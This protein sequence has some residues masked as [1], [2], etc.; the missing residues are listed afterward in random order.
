[1]S[2]GIKRLGLAVVAVVAIGFSALSAV[3]LLVSADTVRERVKEQIRT[4]TGLDPVLSGDVTVSLFPTGSVQFSNISLGDHRTGT[5]ALTA[6][7]LVVRLQFFPFLTGQIEIAD[8]TLVRPTITIAF[9]QGSS[10]WSDHVDML[11]NALRPNPNRVKSF[12]E[13]RISDGT[14]IVRN[15]NDK[16]V[17][18]LTDVEFALAW[19]AISQ[20]FAATGRF[21]WHDEPIDVTLSLTDFLAA[22]TGERSGLKLRL[23]GPPLKFAYDG[24]ISHRPTLK[25]EGALSAD[26]A[27]LRDTLR[28]AARWT[29]PAGGFNRFT[30]KAQ[31]NVS[32]RSVSLSGVNVELDGNVGEGVLSFGGDRRKLL[33]GTLAAGAIDLTP[34]LSTLHLLADDE[35]NRQPITLAGLAGI[36]V[37]LRLSAG[38]VSL[39]KINLGRTAVATNL[40]GGDLTVAVGESQAFGGIAGGTFGLAQSEAG[41]AFKAQMKFT[42][43]DLTQGLGEL[44]GIRRIEGKGTVVVNV[45]GAGVSV[46][47]L[48]QGLNGTASLIST[49]GAIQGVNVEQLLKRLEHNPLAIRGDFRNGKT[50]YDTLTADLKVT[51]GVASVEDLRVEAP[52]MRIALAGSASIPARDLDLKGA[53]GLVAGPDA[54]PTFELPFV[55]TGPWD[56]PLVWP[57]TQAILG[58][59]GVVTPIMDA[60]RSR[61]R[62][63][64]TPPGSEPH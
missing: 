41:A 27:S 17:E 19:P 12:S 13:I 24:Y 9:V 54:A 45:D 38:R 32:G 61:L 47:E 36:D 55:V 52:G 1:M 62:R 20:T 23:S 14:V 60:V 5:S 44:I 30:L 22:L 25:M 31:T 35:W 42:D 28:W 8:V 6:E 29:A 3:S 2:A 64:L 21:V 50:P 34:Y 39:G 15:D 33:Q 10:N 40:R 49:K 48:T 46:Y 26:T 7:Q 37:D 18:T 53:A 56:N 11:A 16:I 4:V 59:A 51:Q 58:R 57:D 63:N 43:M